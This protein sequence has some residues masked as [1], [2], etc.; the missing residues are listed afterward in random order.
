LDIVRFPFRKEEYYLPLLPGIVD[1]AEFRP[2]RKNSTTNTLHVRGSRTG[3]TLHLLESFSTTNRYTNANNLQL[4]PEAIEE[5]E[6]HTGAY[7][8]ELGSTNGGVIASRMKS[9]G[10]SLSLTVRYNTDQLANP[11]DELLNTTSNGYR[12]VVGTIGGPL[13][14]GITFFLA[15]EHSFAANREPRFLEPFKYS[16]TTDYSWPYWYLYGERSLPR[17]VEIR[18]NFLE[19]NWQ[20]TDVVQGN[21]RMDFSPFQLKVLGA[22]S[23]DEKPNGKGWGVPDFSSDALSNYFWQKQQLSEEKKLF[24]ALEGSYKLNP[25]TV[26]RAGISY[27]RRYART[28]DNDFG[29]D[30]RLYADSTAA[31]SKGYILT[32][33]SVIP[34]AGSTGW[35]GLR[36][37]P[38]AY[39]SILTFPFTHEFAPVNNYSKEIQRTEELSFDLTTKISAEW[40]LHAGVKLERWSISLWSIQYINYLMFFTDLMSDFYSFDS[41][42]AHPERIASRDF[43]FA[44][45]GGVDHF[46]YDVLGNETSSGPHRSR[47]PKFLSLFVTNEWR[48]GPL[49]ANIGARYES[50]W[51]GILVH[52]ADD[53]TFLKYSVVL[54]D[55][56]TVIDPNKLEEQPASKYFLPRASLAVQLS[57]HSTLS[58]S[59]GQY[60]Q[61]PDLKQVYHGVSQTDS[62]L[63]PGGF[64]YDTSSRRYL[65]LWFGS[66]L[67]G[68]TM[69]AERSSQF[70]ASYRGSLA[71]L[72]S[73]SLSIY[74]KQLRDQLQLGYVRD[75]A[76]VDLV[77][78]GEGVARGVDLT[79]EIGLSSA[80][81]FGLLYSLNDSRGNTSNPTSNARSFSD[82][83]VRPPLSLHPYDYSVSHRGTTYFSFT[84]GSENTLIEKTNLL[85]LF[86]V[87]SGHA[88]TRIADYPYLGSSS[89][90]LLGARTLL[91]QRIGNPIES[92][93]NST[94]PWESSIDV[95]L[96][97]DVSIPP[98][99]LRVS[100]EVVN[101]LNTKNVINVYPTTGTAS[102]DGWFA[103]PVSQV[104]RQ[105]PQYES[106]Y[107]D[108]NNRN[109]WG[110]AIATGKSLYGK[111]RQF[112]LGLQ[113]FF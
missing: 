44:E 65:P 22:Y 23:F 60:A 80:T 68:Q 91:D 31:R 102:A 45:R 2:F 111:P 99:Q 74:Q 105:V 18:R 21:I 6:I 77:N 84:G 63:K 98:A 92:P 12:A 103:N 43:A 78:T 40:N 81:R 19:G 89:P 79:F 66:A 4:I 100:V 90:W 41:V 14:T 50:F 13:T 73:F 38:P 71:T 20:K 72:G 56:R 42:Y 28:Y 109:G 49:T 83:P 76:F 51:S 53:P 17:P 86:S 29:D 58:V 7:G 97:H 69:K 67:T 54:E 61:L 9:G 110:Y 32:E 57:P 95:V 75:T 48:D 85:I 104:Y 26:L 36:F 34:Q 88:Y 55:G 70:E 64:I 24:V 96:S 82:F 39:R 62:N 15:G 33:N 94:T 1:L 93:N 59:Y 35:Y 87:S 112:R 37:G 113:L 107:S 46:G 11:G 101:V 108:I 52:P 106:F 8:A 16:L 10:E 5:I 30:W 27:R 25:S 47:T 3:E